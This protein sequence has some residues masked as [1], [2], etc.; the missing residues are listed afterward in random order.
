MNI[1]LYFNKSFARQNAFL[2]FLEFGYGYAWNPSSI[3]IQ[4]GDKVTFSWSQQNFIDTELAI[5]IF[6]VSSLFGE[7][8]YNEKGFQIPGSV[9][10]KLKLFDSLFLKKSLFLFLLCYSVEINSVQFSS[11]FFYFCSAT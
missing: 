1:N 11:V 6:T 9:K 3:D 8:V 7:R 10:G 5:D 4:H 2:L